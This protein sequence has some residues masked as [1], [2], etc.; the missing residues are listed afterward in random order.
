MQQPPQQQPSIT[1]PAVT[2]SD[3]DGTLDEYSETHVYERPK[4]AR[5]FDVSDKTVYVYGANDP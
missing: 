3:V 4:K 1:L 2:S 5:D